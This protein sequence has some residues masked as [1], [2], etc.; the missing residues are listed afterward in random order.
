VPGRR[1]ALAPWDDRLASR[2]ADYLAGKHEL[3]RNETEQIGYRL[4]RTLAEFA[5]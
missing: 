4:L 2:Y 1:Q 5:K 3:S